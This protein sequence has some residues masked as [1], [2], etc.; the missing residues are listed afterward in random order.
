VALT[1]KMQVVDRYAFHAGVENHDF[2]LHDWE[3]DIPNISGVYAP[4]WADDRCSDYSIPQPPMYSGYSTK[5]FWNGLNANMPGGGELMTPNVDDPSTTEN[6][7]AP[8]PADGVAYPRMTAAFTYFR[9]LPNAVGNASGEGFEGITTDGTKYTFGWM[10]SN[11]QPDMQ[12]PESATSQGDVIGYAP[13]M[14]R[15][16]SL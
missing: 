13:V 12:R 1:R 10:A 9:C 14:R 4:Y 11:D 7:A 16:L 2:P 5:D 8:R 3:L 6:E 15:L